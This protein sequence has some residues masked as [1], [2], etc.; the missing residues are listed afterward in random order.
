MPRNRS[1]QLLDDQRRIYGDAFEKVAL[2]CEAMAQAMTYGTTL[3][4]VDLYNLADAVRGMKK[5]YGLELDIETP[6]VVEPI[7][8]LV[9]R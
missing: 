7:R 4:D 6:T 5:V 8:R 2:I 9:S 3:C 1:E